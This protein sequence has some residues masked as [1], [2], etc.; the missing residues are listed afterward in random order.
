MNITL[1]TDRNTTNYCGAQFLTIEEGNMI[2][3]KKKN[4]DNAVKIPLNEISKYVDVE[5][6]IRS[7]GSKYWD[8]EENLKKVSWLERLVIE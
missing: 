3:K 6:S 1:N 4:K 8:Y 2:L 7:K 5:I